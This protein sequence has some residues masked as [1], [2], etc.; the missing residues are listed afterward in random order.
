METT[1]NQLTERPSD[2]SKISFAAD[3]FVQDGVNTEYTVNCGYPRYVV[4]FA[5]LEQAQSCARKRN[6]EVGIDTT[7]RMVRVKWF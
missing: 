6:R 1:T 2:P 3:C 7:P 5:S 4:R